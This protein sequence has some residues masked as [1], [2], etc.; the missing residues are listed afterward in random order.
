M[1]MGKER[2]ARVISSHIKDLDSVV[3]YS[4]VF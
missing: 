4:D 1:A 3:R 2:S